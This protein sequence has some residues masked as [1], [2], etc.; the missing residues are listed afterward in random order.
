VALRLRPDI[1]QLN[2][3]IEVY[4]SVKCNTR[5]KKVIELIRQGFNSGLIP[6]LTD[7]GTS[8]T[9]EMRNLQKEKIAIF[10]PIDE[11]P[12]APNNPRGHLGPFGS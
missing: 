8:G 11:E 4:G 5:M 2:S 12:F 9:Y 7:D 3:Y 1:E 10:K 6:R